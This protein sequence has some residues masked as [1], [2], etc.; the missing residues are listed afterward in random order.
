MSEPKY[1]YSTEFNDNKKISSGSMDLDNKKVNV[2]TSRTYHL[3][4]ASHIDIWIVFS[5]F[6]VFTIALPYG[7]WRQG[8]NSYNKTYNK[9]FN[10][11]EVVN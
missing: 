9:L 3:S 7:M 11:P 2:V 8:E 4:Y 6:S 5:F 10:S 1:T